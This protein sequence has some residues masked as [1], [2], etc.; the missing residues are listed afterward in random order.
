MQS[1]HVHVLGVTCGNRNGYIV[2][3]N[4]IISILWLSLLPSAYL[5]YYISSVYT[6]SHQFVYLFLLINLQECVL[7]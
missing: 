2:L 1:I 5:S 4:A 3:H 6:H 7:L